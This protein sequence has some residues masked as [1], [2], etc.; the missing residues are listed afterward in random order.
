MQL[1]SKEWIFTLTTEEMLTIK[2][3][4]GKI[5][6]NISEEIGLSKKEFDILDKA[7]WD[8][9]DTIKNMECDIE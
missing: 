5:N 1:I 9:E 3:A 8:M 2:K 7:Y 6:E 4:I